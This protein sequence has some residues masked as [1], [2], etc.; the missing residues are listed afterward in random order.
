MAA[1]LNEP[2]NGA[3]QPESGRHVYYKTPEG[4]AEIQI[5]SINELLLVKY[6]RS[7][8]EFLELPPN[9][10]V[11]ELLLG[12]GRIEVSLA[13]YEPEWSYIQICYI[14]SGICGYPG[15]AH[16]G[17]LATMLDDGFFRCLSMAF[18]FRV[19]MTAH[20]ELDYEAPTFTDQFVVLRVKIGKVDGRKAW[21]EG[22]IETLVDNWTESPTVLVRADA[23]FVEPT[24][25]R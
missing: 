23:L 4:E 7:Q 14:G 5:L 1:P 22:Q 21:V 18:P 13:W 8:P 3:L 17:F 9:G 20:L 12:P 10:L 2:A 25:V 16:G 11:S 15:V 6:F 19:M 24:A